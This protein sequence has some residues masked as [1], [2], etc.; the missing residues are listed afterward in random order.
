MKFK[1]LTIRAVILLVF[2]L[3]FFSAYQFIFNTR[4]FEP[5][6]VKPVTDEI[7]ADKLKDVLFE[8]TDPELGINIVDL[9]LVRKIQVTPGKKAIIEIVLTSPFCPYSQFI[10]GAIKQR[11]ESLQQIDA[12]EVVLN[13]GAVWTPEYLSPRGKKLIEERF[14]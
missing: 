3:A 9:G 13:K 10:T 8:V 4:S 7:D 11:V 2:S 14:R 12:V 5:E 6:P 1:K